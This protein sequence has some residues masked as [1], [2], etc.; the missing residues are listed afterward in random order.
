MLTETLL[1]CETM[2][3]VQSKLSKPSNCCSV[4]SRCDVMGSRWQMTNKMA[5][6]ATTVLTAFFCW[7]FVLSPHFSDPPRSGPPPAL[8]IGA[9]SMAARRLQIN[10]RLRRVTA[11]IGMTY[12]IAM[13]KVVL[14]VYVYTSLRNMS[15]GLNP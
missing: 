5:I 10:I 15:V 12:T 2:R 8:R 14:Y 6:V 9:E 13:K 11:D 4:Y 7:F 3:R 1:I